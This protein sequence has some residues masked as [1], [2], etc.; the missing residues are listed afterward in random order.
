MEQN[1][2]R[3]R[4]VLLKL[5]EILYESKTWWCFGLEKPSALDAHLIVFIARLTDIERTDLI[6]EALK[7]YAAK[8]MSLP[9]WD[10]V[11]HGRATKPPGA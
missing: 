4:Q 1:E 7:G 5:D 6:P 8:A 9:Q 2:A 11:M 10:E 3:A